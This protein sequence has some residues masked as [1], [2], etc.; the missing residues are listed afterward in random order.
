MRRRSADKE[1]RTPKP[2]ANVRQP[3]CD[4]ARQPES[5]AIEGMGVSLRNSRT[6]SLLPETATLWEISQS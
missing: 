4:Y 3:E 2:N 5:I 1:V 6:Q